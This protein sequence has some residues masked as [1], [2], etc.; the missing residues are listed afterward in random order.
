[1]DLNT[2][3]ECSGVGA[4]QDDVTVL[5][6]KSGSIVEGVKGGRLCSADIKSY[7]SLIGAQ[8]DKIATI[9]I[10]PYIPFSRCLPIDGKPDS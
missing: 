1:V 3:Y 9:L 6:G 10:S 4:K 7:Q 8:K 2:K 5:V